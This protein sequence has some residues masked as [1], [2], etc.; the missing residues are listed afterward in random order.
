MPQGSSLV[1]LSR[2]EVIDFTALINA[3]ETVHITAASDVWPLEP[4]P[5]DHPVR[6]LPGFL[7]SAHRAGALQQ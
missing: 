5:A 1:L 4:M 6:Q 2:A 3:V 7:K